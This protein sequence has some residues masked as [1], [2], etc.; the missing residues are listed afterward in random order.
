ME[1]TPWSISPPP[2]QDALFF[3]CISLR[4]PLP[5]TLRRSSAA[6][7]PQESPAEPPNLS[8]ALW[9]LSIKRESLMVAFH[10][11]SSIRL[12]GTPGV[13]SAALSFFFSFLLAFGTSAASSAA[14]ST[15]HF[16]CSTFSWAM[17]SEDF[18]LFFFGRSS[19]AA[20][21][22]S[23]SSSAASAAAASSSAEAF[24][25][26]FFLGSSAP[27]SPFVAMAGRR[28]SSQSL[29]ASVNSK[30]ARAFAFLPLPVPADSSKDVSLSKAF[31]AFCRPL[32]KRNRRTAG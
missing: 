19:V 18:R 28:P 23:A 7:S 3:F 13:L 10:L 14:S 21:V 17:A 25:F 24:L 2:L 27:A 26:F 22:C 6:L 20:E 8:L 15:S 4:K 12:K 16:G 5:F 30:S 31:K 11:S 29:H 1:F 9:V 32:S